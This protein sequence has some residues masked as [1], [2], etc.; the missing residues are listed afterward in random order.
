MSIFAGFSRL[1]AK[2]GPF[3]YAILVLPLG[4][5]C[6]FLRFCYGNVRWTCVI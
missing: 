2:R 6:A 5:M 3:V 4:A 1:C